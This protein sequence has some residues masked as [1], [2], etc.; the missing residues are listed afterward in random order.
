MS[1]TTAT[2][3]DLNE[4]P[5][6]RFLA[7]TGFCDSRHPEIRAAAGTLAAF[8][9]T[10]RRVAVALF[11]W[12]RDEI[13]YFL[14]PWGVTASH[15]LR[16]R[17]GTCTTK[18]N[19]L[20]ALLRAAGIPAGYGVL[21]V[22]AQR[23]WGTIGPA[24]LTRHANAS[25]THVHAAA[26]LN[27]RWVRCD[28]SSDREIAG[29]TA[30]FCVQNRLMHWDGTAD[31]TDLFDPRHVHAQNPNVLADIDEL[32]AKPPRRST[33][34]AFGCANR[35][36]RFIRASPAFRDE[37]ELQLAYAQTED[38]QASL[39]YLEGYMRERGIDPNADNQQPG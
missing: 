33:P 22:D 12:V 6:A 27:G 1:A 15:T 19:L 23:Y 31:R 25:S 38:F 26:F 13:P 4:P 17:E 34:E 3:T 5:D 10:P 29:K 20:V 18:S 28:P 35:Y 9:P 32:L 11:E 2:A 7:A 14:G 30:H 21:R 36:I 16:I 24:F 39:A 37:R 8:A